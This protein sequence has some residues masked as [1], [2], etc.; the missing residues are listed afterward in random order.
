MASKPR[1]VVIGGGFAGLESA[2]Y[3]RHKLHDK[4]DITLISASNYFLFKPNTIYV[5][6]GENP[7][8]FKID[9]AEPTRRKHIDFIHA[10]AERIDPVR[11]IVHIPHTEVA[12]DYLVVATGAAMRPAE[13]P[14]L[15]ENSVTIWTPEDMLR[16]RDRYAAVVESAR[17]GRRSRIL[18][19][20]PP[21]N[22]CAGPLYEMGMMT[23]TWLREQG[24][25][26]GVE[27]TWST[28]E[29]NY[30]QAFGPRLDTAVNEEFETRGIFGHKAYAATEVK[31]GEVHYA[32]GQVLSYD[33]LVS[34][35]PYV[36]A[37]RFDALPSDDRGFIDVHPD[38]RRVRG[39]DRIYA[40]GDAGNFPVKQAFLAL[41]QADAAADHIAAEILG[42]TAQLDFHPMSMCVMEE[43]DKATF[44]Q[45][46]LRY[47]G[48][49]NKPV[50][51]DL[52][53]TEH[54]KVGVSPV[55]RVGKKILGAY[56]PWRFGHG[57]PFHSGFAWEAM[58]LGLKVMA[59]V[60]AR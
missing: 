8:N 29:D 31:P 25:R 3:L 18:F 14:G 55:W 1:V 39:M 30:I 50:T 48:D 32:N 40:A 45:V 16:L 53:D 19:L 58:E 28:Y 60:M 37:N 49:P 38:S 51:V 7:E 57:E 26:D 10:T 6:F 59:K 5:P 12:F 44:A 52:E 20:V 22:R 36:A 13:I 27:I 24:V 15:A 35:P 54:Y 11:R 46:P 2:F 34:F 21:H 4:V 56:L 41:L 9:L 42:E 23:D 33:L 47:T 43:F 17:A